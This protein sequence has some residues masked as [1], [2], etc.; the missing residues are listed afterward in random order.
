MR[1]GVR[2]ENSC[3]HKTWVEC[4]DML[5]WC[6]EESMG[7]AFLSLQGDKY[8]YTPLPKTLSQ[9]NLDAFLG[10][11]DC[12]EELKTLISTWYILDSN[13]QPK[14]Y[15]LKNLVDKDD[16]DYWN[17]YGK[18]L[19]AIEGISFD[20]QHPELQVGRSVTE[21]EVRAAHDNY[22]VELDKEISFCWSHRQLLGEVDN[23]L[24][25]DVK[26]DSTRETY[27]HNL[28]T[29]VTEEF[30][31][32]MV[33]LY[34]PIALSDL[35]CD[36]VAKPGCDEQQKYMAE[37]QSF[38]SDKLTR[39][40]QHIIAQKARWESDGCGLGLPG[41]AVSEALHHLSNAHQKC[42]GFCGRSALVGH[43][44]SMILEP[45]R[46]PSRGEIYAGINLCLVGISGTG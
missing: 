24:Y 46:T 23:T 37:F 12:S 35:V 42:V 26:P 31:P 27:L 13:A 3:D 7:I 38:M 22:P 18:I 8:G 15:V 10:T 9:D 25:R 28:K 33:K 41:V 29:F 1:W 19:P 36:P 20:A 11:T 14:E 40:L 4:A 17:A 43:A 39:S 30:P 45:N 44:L 32:T 2:D 5:H 6:K 16:K 34:E 21:W